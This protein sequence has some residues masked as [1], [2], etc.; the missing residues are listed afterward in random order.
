[1]GQLD[2]SYGSGRSTNRAS[3]ADKS[4]FVERLQ[5]DSHALAERR[6]ARARDEGFSVRIPEVVEGRGGTQS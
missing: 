4:A 1:M 6:P 3:G 5:V 2:Q